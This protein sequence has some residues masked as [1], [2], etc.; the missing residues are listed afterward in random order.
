MTL[1]PLCPGG[2]CRVA[3]APDLEALV[4][5]ELREPVVSLAISIQPSNLND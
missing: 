3:V 4:R 1:P 5:E 2:N